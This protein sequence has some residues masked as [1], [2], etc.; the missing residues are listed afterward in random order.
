MTSLMV[1]GA[2][3]VIAEE[4]EDAILREAAKAIRKHSRSS[5]KSIIAIGDALL[6]AKATLKHG[7][8]SSWIVRECGFTIRSAQNYIRAFEFAK[9]HGETVALLTPGA[10]Y[11]LSASNT[12][13]EVVRHVLAML[14]R[15]FVPAEGDIDAMINLVRESSE[16]AGSADVLTTRTELAAQLASELR[17][18]LGDEWS[19]EL[20]DGPWDLIGKSLRLQ[21]ATSHPAVMEPNDEAND[22]V[23]TATVLTFPSRQNGPE[24]IRLASEDPGSL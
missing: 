12:P 5:T 20:A 14:A 2:E 24:P 10:I 17:L 9:H 7:D 23:R 16:A 4:N 8:F 1:N 18:R 22:A 3:T 11:R 15:N 21:L 19:R 13:T 6:I